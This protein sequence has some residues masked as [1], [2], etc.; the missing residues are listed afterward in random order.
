MLHIQLSLPTNLW[1]NVVWRPHSAERQLPPVALPVV[2]LL[3]LCARGGCGPSRHAIGIHELLALCQR[4]QR[5]HIH[6]FAET[7]V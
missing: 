3:R 6:W 1:C 7:K 5:G 4:G 2:Q